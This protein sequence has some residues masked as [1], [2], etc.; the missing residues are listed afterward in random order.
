MYDLSLDKSRVVKL[1]KIKKR[2]TNPTKYFSDTPYVGLCH[3]LS[4]WLLSCIAIGG[5]LSNIIA[6]IGQF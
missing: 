4:G 3:S 6:V 2:L 5:I 1:T